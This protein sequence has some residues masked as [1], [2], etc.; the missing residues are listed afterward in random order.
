M[1]EK[2]EKVM[3]VVPD[4]KNQKWLSQREILVD[5]ANDHKELS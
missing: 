1:Q 3:I 4:C 5:N 2:L